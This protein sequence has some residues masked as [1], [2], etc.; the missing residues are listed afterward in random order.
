[1]KKIKQSLMQLVALATLA[2]FSGFASA[3]T[4]PEDT[5]SLGGQIYDLF[6]NQAYDSG[7]AF[8][9]SGVL[10]LLALIQIKQ[11]WKQA[12]GLA[13]GAGGVAG[14]PTILTAIGAAI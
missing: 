7:M 8:I 1:M 11:D 9:L 10:L 12:G 2:V 14:L 4:A 6:F 13:I 3:A 5:D